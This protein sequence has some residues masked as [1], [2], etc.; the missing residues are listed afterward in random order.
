MTE[1]ARA[2]TPE[3]KEKRGRDI[4][5]V[6]RSLFEKH[7]YKDISMAQIARTAGVAKG[8]V[9]IYY[10][11]REELFLALA[12]EYFGEFFEDMENRITELALQG[13]PSSEDLTAVLKESFSG[14]ES[15]LKIIPLLGTIIEHNSGYESI[16]EFKLFLAEKMEKTGCYVEG[17]FPGLGGGKGLQLFLWLYGARRR[18]MRRATSTS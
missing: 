15:F 2:R 8:T 12:R 14:K 3:E 7:P 10:S 1:K 16:R 6:A 13:T 11:T 4:L 9:F 17:I 5:N 18:A